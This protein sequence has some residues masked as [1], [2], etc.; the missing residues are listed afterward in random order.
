MDRPDLK[1]LLDS[2]DTSVHWVMKMVDP[3]T[4]SLWASPT[5]AYSY[6]V[7][8]LYNRGSLVFDVVSMC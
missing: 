2:Y 3:V 6:H 8:I 5:V 4:D 1:K 7:S